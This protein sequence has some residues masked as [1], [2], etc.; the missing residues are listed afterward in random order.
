MTPKQT[1]KI[2]F[3]VISTIIFIGLIVLLVLNK[4]N[5]LI[6]SDWLFW[7]AYIIGS[8]FWFDKKLLYIKKQFIISLLL[9]LMFLIIV[10]IANHNYIATIPLA[11]I[12]GRM[13]VNKIL[14][15]S[16]KIDLEAKD[17]Q[18][19]NTEERI[20]MMIYFVMTAVISG[21]IYL[22]VSLV[23]RSV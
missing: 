14:D 13:I 20:K 5:T 22:V 19:D 8:W 7:S 9:C 12:I 17:E 1:L 10:G 16:R 23:C 2:R 3:T 18:E 15:K 6:V 4:Y 11:S 21:I